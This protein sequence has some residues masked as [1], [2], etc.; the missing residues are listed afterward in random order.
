MSFVWLWWMA[1]DGLRST[2]RRSKL[3]KKKSGGAC[4]KQSYSN[5]VC[6]CLQTQSMELSQKLTKSMPRRH[7]IWV[8]TKCI[9]RLKSAEGVCL[10]GTYFRERTVLVL[11]PD[12]TLSQEKRSGDFLGCVVKSIETNSKPCKLASETGLHQKYVI[13][14]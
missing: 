7:L 11:C 4:S 2:L 6:T 5:F 14:D 10:K 9:W 13:I 3:K 8:V 12:P 1:S